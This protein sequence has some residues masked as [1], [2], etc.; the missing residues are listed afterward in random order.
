ME[1]PRVIIAI[2]SDHAGHRLK[3]DLATRLAS[4][5]HDVLDLGGSAERSDY[6]HASE[7]VGRAVAEG[8]AARGVLV[9]GSGIGVAIAANKVAGVRAAT[10]GEPVSARLCREHNDVNVICLGERLIGP[11]MAWECVRAFLETNHATDGRH[12]LRVAQIAEIEH[13]R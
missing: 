3:D 11:E 10:I 7:A 12:A 9:C 13:G 5:G 8:Q 2:A 1:G 6:P 4:A